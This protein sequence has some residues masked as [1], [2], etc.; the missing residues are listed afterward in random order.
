MSTPTNK[1]SELEKVSRFTWRKK[2]PDKATLIKKAEANVQR[3]NERA[4]P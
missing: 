2:T 4:K 3:R 1:W